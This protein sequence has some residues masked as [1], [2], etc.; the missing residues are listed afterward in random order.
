MCLQIFIQAFRHFR[1]PGRGGA[2]DPDFSVDLS[3]SRANFRGPEIL[4]IVCR[5]CYTSQADANS[6]FSSGEYPTLML[7]GQLFPRNVKTYK[8]D[9]ALFGSRNIFVTPITPWGFCISNN[10]SRESLANWGTNTFPCRYRL[11]T[12]VWDHSDR[13]LFVCEGFDLQ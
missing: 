4:Y 6:S 8:K 7:F 5:N 13:Y 10:S 9:S 3:R 11:I 12:P 2:Y 1:W